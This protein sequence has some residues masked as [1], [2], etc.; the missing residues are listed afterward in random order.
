M[1]TSANSAVPPVRTGISPV[2]PRLTARNKFG[3]SASLVASQARE[4][5]VTCFR[6]TEEAYAL[7][8]GYEVLG[9]DGTYAFQT[10]FATLHAFNGWA[11]KFLTTPPAGLRD[12]YLEYGA[13]LGAAQAWQAVVAWHDFRADAGDADYGTEWDAMLRWT[14]GPHLELEAKAGDYRS[15]GFARDTTK[16]WFAAT[17]RY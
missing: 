5:A 17:V 14:Q 3:S 13:K 1:P 4:A 9:G 7:R 11:D 15:D 10:P 6:D 2:T 12:G 8:A 16:V